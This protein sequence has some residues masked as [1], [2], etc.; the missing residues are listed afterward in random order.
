MLEKGEDHAVGELVY[1]HRELIERMA[2]ELPGLAFGEQSI[3]HPIA[4]V[5]EDCVPHQAKV[6]KAPQ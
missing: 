2:V 3:L 6:V 4:P 5:P 1:V